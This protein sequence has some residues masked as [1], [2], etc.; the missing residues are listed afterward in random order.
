[1]T[2]LF[3]RITVATLA[4]ALTAASFAQDVDKEKAMMEAWQKASTPGEPHKKLDALVGTFDAR[5]RSTVDPSKPPED[6][7]GTSVNSWVLGGRYVEQQYDGA[8]MGEP[9]TGIGFTGYDNVQKK[10]VSVWMDTAGTGMMWMTAAS[11]K[12]GK[13]LSGSARIWDPVTGKPVTVE[14]KTIITD[15]DHHSFEMWGKAPNGKTTKLMEI[16]YTRRK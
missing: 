4:L 7:V 14:S 15:N 8:F 11:D 12:S 2:R 10:Y 16:Q 1:M 9:F 5:V 3:G 6:S 13:S